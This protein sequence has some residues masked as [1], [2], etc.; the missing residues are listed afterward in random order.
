MFYCKCHCLQGV[1]A[2]LY[3]VYVWP[4]VCSDDIAHFPCWPNQIPRG[5]NSSREHTLRM[6]FI[7]VIVERAMHRAWSTVM[8]NLLLGNWETIHVLNEV[9]HHFPRL[10][11]SQSFHILNISLWSFHQSPESMSALD[12]GSWGGGETEKRLT[13][14]GQLVYHMDM[15]MQ[16]K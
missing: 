15:A 7:P 8:R 12:W 13:V 11:H 10:I 3:T 1:F 5:W 4:E 16:L 2:A 14:N 9:V 6:R